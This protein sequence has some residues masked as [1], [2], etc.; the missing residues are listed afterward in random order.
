MSVTAMI[1]TGLI[2]TPTAKDRTTLIPCAITTPLRERRAPT[3]AALPT[4]GHHPDG[5]KLGARRRAVIQSR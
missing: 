4:R 1:G 3:L 5:V 2:A